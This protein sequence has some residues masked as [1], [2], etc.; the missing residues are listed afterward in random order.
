MFGRRFTQSI[1]FGLGGLC[2][3]VAPVTKAAFGYTLAPEAAKGLAIAGE[4]LL[5]ANPHCSQS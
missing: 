2:L 4:H 5:Q 3:L 1:F